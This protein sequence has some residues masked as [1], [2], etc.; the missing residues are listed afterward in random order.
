M[1]P[2]RVIER[3]HQ[4]TGGVQ[5]ERSFAMSQ[6]ERRLDSNRPLS[7]AKRRPQSRKRNGIN[8]RVDAGTGP[9]ELRSCGAAIN[10][11]RRFCPCDK[12][13]F[14]KN[15]HKGN[16]RRAPESMQRSGRGRS[17]S[18]LKQALDQQRNRSS[19]S[20]QTQ[21]SRAVWIGSAPQCLQQRIVDLGVAKAAQMLRDVVNQDAL[22]L[23][24]LRVRFTCDRIEE[25][26]DQRLDGVRTTNGRKPVNRESPRVID[27]LR[28][29]A[30]HLLQSGNRALTQPH[31][32]VK[33]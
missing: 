19:L 15:L 10:P 25:R 14:S 16:D 21:R 27:G 24:S 8:L 12:P 32:L 31:H 1:R 7:V 11:S 23:Q 9:N 2:I 4:Y 17:G 13:W 20:D 22:R 28:W 6:G 33:H 26:T 3:H 29:P 18:I 30:Y 5:S